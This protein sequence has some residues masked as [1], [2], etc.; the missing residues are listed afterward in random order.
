[1]GTE[2]LAM[3]VIFPVFFWAADIIL[4]LQRRNTIKHFALMSLGIL[5]LCIGAL[6]AYL[7]GSHPMRGIILTSMFYPPGYILAWFAISLL[8]SQGHRRE[9]NERTAA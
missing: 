1:M 6:S 2:I 7:N 5:C 8:A 3:F 4:I 9:E